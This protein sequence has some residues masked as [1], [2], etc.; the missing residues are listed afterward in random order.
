[1]LHSWCARRSWDGSADCQQ[2]EMT[3]VMQVWTHVGGDIRYAFCR[4]FVPGCAV[5]HGIL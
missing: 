3:I 2:S 5:G 1:M 4:V